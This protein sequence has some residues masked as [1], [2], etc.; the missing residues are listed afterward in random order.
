MS[1]QM[2]ES[3]FK[4]L[5]VASHIL[6]AKQIVDG[7]GHVSVRHPTDPTLFLISRS[8]APALVATTDIMAIDLD[9]L[10]TPGE[11]RPAFLERFIHAGIYRARSDVMAV[12]HSHSPA[13]IPFGIVSGVPLRP[14]FHMCG[15]L[16][17]GP[18]VFEIR[19]TA[20]TASDMLIRSAEL[21][22]ALATALGSHSTLLMRGHGSTVVGDSLRQAVFR[23]IY[24]E[25]NARIVSMAHSLG[26]VSYLTAEEAHHADAAN[27]A[28]AGR[29]WELWCRE[30]SQD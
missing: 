16:A 13:V 3:T 10:P 7:F 27:A 12:V 18:P 23:A 30:V 9:G 6:A 4:D 17:E 28:Q 21:G 29:A 15:F 1:G 25:T 14:A 20:G 8:M 11:T 26:A 19:D 22:V 5:V 24:L 2:L